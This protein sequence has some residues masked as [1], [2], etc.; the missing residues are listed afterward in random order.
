MPDHKPEP[1][2]KLPFSVVQIGI[3]I[4][5]VS[6]ATILRA[7]TFPYIGITSPY[8]LFFPSTLVAAYFGGLGGGILA[9]IFGTFAAAFWIPPIGSVIIDFERSDLGGLVAF[10]VVQAMLITIVLR[11]RSSQLRGQEMLAEATS[12]KERSTQILQSISDCVYTVGRELRFRYVNRQAE[13]FFGRNAKELIGKRIGE[14]FP[15]FSGSELEDAFGQAIDLGLPRF[16]ELIPPSFPDRWIDLRLYPSPDTLSVYFID[17][18]ERRRHEE[19]LR[20][21][22]TQLREQNS[23]LDAVISQLPC[24][25]LVTDPDGR[26]LN[27]NS[28]AKVITGFEFARGELLGDNFE[29]LGIVG[30]NSLGH[31]IK[32]H[33][34]PLVRALTKGE[35]TNNEEIYL[36]RNNGDR[37]VLSVAATPVHDESGKPLAAVSVFSDVTVQRATAQA[38]ERSEAR[39]RA[40]ANTDAFGIVFWASDGRLVDANKKFFALL[41]YSRQDISR[42]LLWKD[43]VS[44]PEPHAGPEL[45]K[46]AAGELRA[47]LEV[48][49]RGN[50]G[51]TVPALVY[52]SFLPG[53]AQSGV[54]FILDNSAGYRNYD[55]EQ[56]RSEELVRNL[57]DALP[58]MVWVA[59]TKNEGTWFNS[60]WLDFTGDSLESQL[61]VG[62]AARVHPDDITPCIEQ[63]EGAF[64]RREP[65]TME[66]RYKRHDGAYRTLL[67]IGIPWFAAN[68]EFRGYLGS[69]IDITDQKQL[70]SEL[71]QRLESERAARAESERVSRMKDEFIATLSHE[72][73]T[74]LNAI[75]G[76][77]QL[78]RRGR[79]SPEE[80]LQGME[81]IERNARLQTRLID[82][83][84]DTSRIVSGKI[85]L[86]NEPISIETAIR[87]AVQSA[88]PHAEG[89]AIEI[90]TQLDLNHAYV[91]G[92]AARLQ[93]VLWNL[94]SNAIKFTPREGRITVSARERGGEVEIVIADSGAGIEPDLLPHIFERFRQ[95]DRATS[96]K[97]G[98]LG[99]GLAIVKQLVELHGGRVAADSEGRGKGA[100]FTVTLPSGAPPETTQIA[101]RPLVAR[102]AEGAPLLGGLSVLVVDDELE[103]CDLA[104]RILEEHGANVAVA[105]GGED[106]LQQIAHAQP[107]VV[108]SDIGMPDI[109]GYELI[110]RLRASAPA[111]GGLTPALALTAFARPEDRSEA[112]SAGYQHHIAKP[113]NPHELVRAVATLGAMTAGSGSSAPAHLQ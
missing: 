78:M 70:E 72:L 101:D 29:R 49:L 50:D 9:A 110:R 26:V 90:E 13:K 20:T 28:Q 17:I 59:D 104:R 51:S 24:G 36:R 25:V 96:R 77:S 80:I 30:Y 85:R 42:G 56:R 102:L 52:S 44:A 37:I 48:H 46:L 8:T 109:D 23:L 108:V 10:E 18:T 47:P 113:I 31:K 93:Q 32:H 60:S 39:F 95:S 5:T 106:A 89:K 63:C 35:A 14:V 11:M 43:L 21:I 16:F 6:V 27:S 81:V 73:R 7:L 94:L 84:L 71:A 12:A 62:W 76:W 57:A 68:Q 4:S 107:D 69:C 53:N 15:N 64:R 74:P 91:H 33:E 3:A 88:R 92:D 55:E 34:W 87:S 112:L 103:A 83:L 19:E 98:G 66:F 22:L 58:V 86:E 45:V 75:L 61:G 79:I 99:L 111:E 105:S 40:V 41:G 82:D 1:R 54:A 2:F 65:F 97:Q 38:L 67:D 100:R